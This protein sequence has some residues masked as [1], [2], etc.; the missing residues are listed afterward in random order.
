VNLSYINLY[1]RVLQMPKIKEKCMFFEVSA[2]TTCAS[3]AMCF[4]A[5]IEYL[6]YPD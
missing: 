4:D 2:V 5:E 1:I 3:K 6:A